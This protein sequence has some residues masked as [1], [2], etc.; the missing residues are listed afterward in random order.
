MADSFPKLVKGFII[1]TLFSFL[2]VGFAV[3]L[4]SN[5]GKDSSDITTK[6]GMADL[7][8][9][10]HLQQA[11]AEEWRKSF[12]QQSVFLAIGG[13][14]LT[15]IFQL[16]N[17][18]GSAII[19]PFKLFGTIFVNILGVPAIVVNIVNVLIIFTMIFGIWRLIKAGW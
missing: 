7:N 6:I 10:L 3:N 2:L 9:T 13:I 4:A 14:V 18:I 11:Q 16:A 8:T 5:Y 15:G 1:L 12:E 17:T 19:L